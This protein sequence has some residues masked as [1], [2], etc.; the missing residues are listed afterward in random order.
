[1]NIDD[2]P[3]AGAV[4]GTDGDGNVYSIEYDP[5]TGI[6]LV[7]EGIDGTVSKVNILPGGAIDLSIGAP[8]NS[9]SDVSCGPGTFGI[10]ARNADGDIVQVTAYP[11]AAGDGKGI[12]FFARN[13]DTSLQSEV[14][15][16]QDG[17]Q[18]NGVTVDP[19][20]PWPG[21]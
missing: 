5:D 2:L 6:A 11:G 14:L 19:T 12:S 8:D 15:I 7:Y 9:S 21:G 20:Q 13:G 1:M 4:G 3:A 16:A 18:I 10:N 17:V